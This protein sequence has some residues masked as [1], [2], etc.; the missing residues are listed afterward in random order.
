MPVWVYKSMYVCYVPIW[1]YIHDVYIISNMGL[2]IGKSNHKVDGKFILWNN[3]MD[4][5]FL[6]APK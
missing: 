4:F 2:A 1:I 6:F 3:Y 5:T